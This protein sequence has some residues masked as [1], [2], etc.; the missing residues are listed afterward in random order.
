MRSRPHRSGCPT[1]CRP[2]RGAVP[3]RPQPT[4]VRRGLDA[5][6]ARLDVGHVAVADHGHLVARGGHRCGRPA[7]RSGCPNRRLPSPRWCHRRAPAPAAVTGSGA[8]VGVAVTDHGDLV[9]GS[10]HRCGRAG[11]GLVARSGAVLPGGAV[12]SGAGRTVAPAC[13]CCRRRRLSSPITVTWLSEASTGAVASPSVWLPD[14]S[15]LAPDV[16]Q[17]R[18][19]PMPMSRTRCQEL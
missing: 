10:V 16:G 14:T 17:A 5:V 19:L 4:G 8:V 1:R 11:I 15:P 3:H 12:G 6:V 13:R 2:A 7:R 18:L 9:V